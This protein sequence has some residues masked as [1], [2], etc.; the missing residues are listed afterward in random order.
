MRQYVIS[1]VEA[2]D[3]PQIRNFNSW[4]QAQD[5]LAVGR[6]GFG[7]WGKLEFSSTLGFRPSLLYDLNP[8]N[9]DYFLSNFD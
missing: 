6:G 9:L 1:Y 7:F 8:A 3:T 2:R 5:S 4:A